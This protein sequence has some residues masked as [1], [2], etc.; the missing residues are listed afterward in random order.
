MSYVATGFTNHLGT[1]LSQHPQLD[2]VPET[3]A[4]FI[5]KNQISNAEL[6]SKYFI[7]YSIEATIQ[8]SG[9]QI[10]L[11]S[12]ITDLLNEEVIASEVYELTEDQIFEY[13]DKIT[14]LALQKMS[15]MDHSISSNQRVSQNPVIYKKFIYIR[16]QH[17]FYDGFFDPKKSRNKVW[18]GADSIIFLKFFY[19]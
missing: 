9:D 16:D 15:T 10:R 19:N 11:S 18:M 2:V 13:Q 14:D 8:V 4:N 1:S 5:D 3:T 6:K 7:N 17:Q 12:K